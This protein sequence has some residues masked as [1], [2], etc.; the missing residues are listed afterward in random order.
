MTLY[1]SIILLEEFLKRMRKLVS[2]RRHVQM[3]INCLPA[4]MLQG[5]QVAGEWFDELQRDFLS[6]GVDVV[7]IP[8][9]GVPFALGHV[10]MDQLEDAVKV[11][12]RQNVLWV[13]LQVK[14][15]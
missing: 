7:D 5:G 13:C 4:K 12:N 1:R 9:V 10:V 6:T 8:T 2:F 14:R 15:G 3:S 11:W